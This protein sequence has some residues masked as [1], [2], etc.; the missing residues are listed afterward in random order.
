MDRPDDND[1]Q[2][3]A[4]PCGQRADYI[5]GDGVNCGECLDGQLETEAEDAI[6]DAWHNEGGQ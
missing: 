5:N 4:C 3:G 1:N 6:I 2:L